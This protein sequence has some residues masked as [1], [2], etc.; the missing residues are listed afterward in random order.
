MVDV[1]GQGPVT[2]HDSADQSYFSSHAG[3]EILSFSAW[4]EPIGECSI[5]M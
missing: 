4:P 1:H 2:Q 5:G 3:C